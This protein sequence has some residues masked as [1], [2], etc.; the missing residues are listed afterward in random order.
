MT[1]RLKNNHNFQLGSQLTPNGDQAE[2]QV[3]KENKT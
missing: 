2:S 1:L 3:H